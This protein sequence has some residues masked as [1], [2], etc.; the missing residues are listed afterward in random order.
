MM[1][2]LFAP[3]RL[4]VPDRR[5]SYPQVLTHSKCIRCLCSTYGRSSLEIP[6]LDAEAAGRVTAELVP[7]R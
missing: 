2:A 4:S 1:S 3:I 5:P 7:I 6:P